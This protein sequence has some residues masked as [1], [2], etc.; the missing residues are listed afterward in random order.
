MQHEG[1]RPTPALAIDMAGVRAPTAAD[2]GRLV[3]LHNRIKA[4]GAR[5]VLLNV[6]EMAREVLEVTRLTEL[7]VVRP[8]GGDV[9]RAA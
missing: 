9:R 6:G 3:E 1:N 2:L 5:L 4:V 7:F 8:A